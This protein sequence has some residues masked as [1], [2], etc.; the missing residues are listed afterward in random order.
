MIKVEN[1]EHVNPTKYKEGTFFISDRGIAVLING[2]L[3]EVSLLKKE[4]KFKGG[5]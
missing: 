1:F 3:R 4:I 2:S 5:K